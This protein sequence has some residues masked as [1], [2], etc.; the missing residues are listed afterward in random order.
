VPDR[1][2]PSLCRAIRSLALVAAHT[3]RGAPLCDTHHRKKRGKA[4]IH[5]LL[6]DVP[7]IGEARRNALLEHF[8]SLQK[9]R[10]ASAEE[11]AARR[12]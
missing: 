9:I 6:D 8:G 11:I 5:S 2:T 1:A 10:A 3:R 12:A 4:Q 7:G